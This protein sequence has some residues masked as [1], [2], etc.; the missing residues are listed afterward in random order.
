MMVIKSHKMGSVRAYPILGILLMLSLM[1]SLIWRPV[2]PAR[3][4]ALAEL[5]ATADFPILAC[6]GIGSAGDDVALHGIRFTVNQ[7]FRAVEVRMAAST[8]GIHTVTA[9]LRQSS[10]FLGD[11]LATAQVTVTLP[12]GGSMPYRPVTFTFGNITVT[13]PQTFTIKFL[14]PAAGGPV[15]YLETFGVGNKPCPNVQETEQNNVANPTERGDPAGFK[16]LAAGPTSL[17]INA[18]AVSTPP[19]I[20]G[21]VGVGEWNLS[22]KVNFENGFMVAANDGIRL[23]VLLD[24]LYDNGNDAGNGDYFWITFDV[25]EDGQIDANL[26]LNYGLAPNGNM[27]YQYYLGPGSRTPLQPATRSSKAKG[28]GCF[29]GDGSMVV[30]SFFPVSITCNAHRIWEFAFDLAEIGAAPGHTIR[31]GFRAASGTPQFTNDVPA[32]FYNDFSN[33]I[34]VTLTNVALPSYSSSATIEF[35]TH[36][37]E[38]TQAIQ[39]RDNSLPLVQDKATVARLYVDADNATASQPVIA[40]LYGSV[41]GVDLPG[42]PLALLYQAPL[43][44]SRAYL[45]QTANFALP[46]TWDQGT[47]T[48]RGKARTLGGSE[49]NTADIPITFNLRQKPTYWYIPINTGS[50]ASPNLI[51]TDEMDS[52]RSYLQTVY[53]VPG[54]R[55]VYKP[56]TAI[57]ATTIANTIAK[58]NEYY[59]VALLAW[60]ASVIL[61]GQAPYAMPDQ[62]YGFTPSG[63]GQSDPVWLGAAGRVARGYRGSSLE[64]TMAH[65][66]NHNLDRSTYGTWGRHVPK[67]CGAAGPDPNW[68]YLDDDIQQVGFDTRQPWVSTPSQKSVVPSNVPDFM[69]YCQ[70]GFL[71]TKWISPYRWNHLYNAFAVPMNT[72]MLRRVEQIQSVYYISG[73]VHQDGSGSLNPA[74]IQPGIPSEPLGEGNAALRI[75]GAQNEVLYNHVFNVAF[76]EDPEEPVEVTYFSFQLPYQRGAKRIVLVYQGNEIASIPFSAHSPVVTLTAPNGGRSFS[77]SKA[78]RPDKVY[79]PTDILHIAWSASDA[80]GDSLYFTLLYTP[81]GQ[82]WYPIVSNIQG[83]SYDLDL[84][85]IPGGAAARIRVIVTDGVN[86][87]QD[88]SDGTFIVED[89]APLVTASAPLVAQPGEQIALMGEAVDPE[90]GPLPDES[91][92]W[93]EGEDVLGTGRELLVSLDAGWHTIT[94]YATDADGNTAQAQ[95]TVWVG[96][97]VFLPLVLR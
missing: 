19:R 4:R 49:I 33:L 14:S 83:N 81:D 27:R 89:H 10:G 88:D 52:Q 62:I 96:Y 72:A 38:F 26:D 36:P 2:L 37:I 86:T 71:P 68:P 76:L 15:Y 40:Y 5:A 77:V 67:G 56:W 91:L 51:S 30:T 61:H 84:N 53:P 95:V 63:S 87:A 22:S 20:D 31:V 90:D 13:S 60:I 92:V 3:A 8:A 85:L 66:I 50:A 45:N 21:I 97:R 43:A 32:N 12:A 7:N 39:K 75:L 17:A 47:V 34:L 11:P 42:S 70:S 44:I 80:D 25:D 55:W 54:V 73:E 69:S 6:P 41:D 79:S 29:L 64:G 18:A 74:F 35:D 58:L 65:E 78:A 82:S 94:L 24:L 48:F 28:F 93:T 23:Y 16:V 1:L 46:D 9:E 59:Q 57:G